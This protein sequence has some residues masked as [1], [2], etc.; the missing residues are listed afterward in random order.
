MEKN[1]KLVHDFWNDASCGEE[2]FL[3]GTKLQDYQNHSKIR[4]ELEGDLIIPFAEFEKSQGLRVLEIGVG[5][6][7]DHQLFAEYKADLYGID[8]TQR[9]IDHTKRRL[10][11]LGLKSNVKLGDAENLE[12]ND[13][14]FDVVY[15]WGVIHHSPSTINC[16][17]EIF[18]V[19]KPG[20]S[21]KIM[22]YHKRSI[23]G[24]ML[25][26]RYAI[27]G[28]KPWLTLNDVFSRYMESPGTK[29][30]SKKEALKLFSKFSHIEIVSKLSHADLLSSNAGQRHQGKLLSIARFLWPR[31]LIKN[32]LPNSGIFLMIKATK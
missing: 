3:K 22:I 17:N 1:K 31:K 29:A 26:F 7:A 27:I 6:G 24:L 2:L 9:S 25:Y 21:A 8:L 14:F 15:S 23:I 10:K 30:Y 13:N 18:R 5:L 12:F 16:V 4:Y 11:D 20:G 32:F 28:F 19:L